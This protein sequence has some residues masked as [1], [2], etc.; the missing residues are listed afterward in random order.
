MLDAYDFWAE[1]LSSEDLVLIDD[2]WLRFAEI[3][4]RIERYFRGL[5]RRIDADGEVK[6]ALGPLAERLVC[7]FEFGAEGKLALVITPE[8]YHSRRALARAAVARAPDLPGWE[9]RDARW[10]V[11]RVP[12]AVRAILG[13][14]RSEALAVEELI[15]RRGAHRLVDLV[16]HGFGDREFLADQG[17]VIFSVLLG[18]RADQD[19][20]GTAYPR[21]WPI[22]A[23]TNLTLARERPRKDRWL[24]EFR[25]RATEIIE[26]FEAER[27]QTRFADGPMRVEDTVSFRLRPRTGDWERRGDAMV[28]QSRH[29]ALTAARL[30]GVRIGGAR[31]SRFREIF[32][33]L[34]IRRTNAT[35]FAEVAEIATLGA[36][37]EETLMTRKIGGVTGRAVGLEHVYIDL[38]LIDLRASIDA[39]RG[40]LGAEGIFGPVWL[41][42]DDA[43]LED[44]YHPLMP[45]TP[46][47]PMQAV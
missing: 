20:L 41:I 38:A 16:A 3:A 46:P 25:E 44:L 26:G 22:L 43:G 17:G 2:F 30:A 42:F 15:P 5:A 18:E 34:K 10:P 4:P 27:P 12:D 47:T 24:S 45:Q 40:M 29:R 14:S 8:L 39:L 1:R 33:G 31:F 11:A 28:Y 9:V 13:R 21:R 36:R 35:P 23:L 6:A 37:I 7:D 32:C 19:W